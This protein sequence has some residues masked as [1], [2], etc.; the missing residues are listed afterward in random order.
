MNIQGIKTTSTV[1]GIAEEVIDGELAVQKLV[2]TTLNPYTVKGDVELLYKCN[3]PSNGLIE[4]FDGGYYRFDI[5][6]PDILH[7]EFNGIQYADII[8]AVKEISK[9]AVAHREEMLLASQVV[10]I[11]D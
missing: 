9:Y 2:I 10:K 5:M 11:E 6:N 1:D 8:L 7:K 4:A 3:T